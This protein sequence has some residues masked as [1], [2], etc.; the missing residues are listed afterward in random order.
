[1]VIILS[2]CA[3]GN[4]VEEVIE[5]TNPP[6]TTPAKT[7]TLGVTTEIFPTSVVFRGSIVQADGAGELPGF[8]YSTSPNPTFG[9]NSSVHTYA[10][11]STNFQVQSGSLQPNTTYYVRGYIKKAEGQYI[12]TSESSFKTTG[13]F[14]PGGGY[15]GYDKGEYSNGWRFMEIHTQGA[16]YGTSPQGAKWGDLNLFIS[17]TYPDFGKGL[18]NSIVIAANNPGLN[19]AA[20]V[21]FDLVRN[22]MSDWFLPSSQELLVLSKELKKANISVYAGGSAWSS[23]Q[24]SDISGFDITFD[25]AGNGV[26]SDMVKPNDMKVFPVR[27]Y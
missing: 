25:L 3:G 18:E 15:V 12:Y 16:Y 17:G 10:L 7:M 21:C 27:R 26:I 8:V 14:G 1:M 20:K 19:C 4:D 13:Y 9:N 6:I 24:K 2:S 23:S 22:G 11:G 5:I